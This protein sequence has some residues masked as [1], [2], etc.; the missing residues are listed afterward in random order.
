MYW[1]WYFL[2]VTQPQFLLLGL[3]GILGKEA[4]RAANDAA[5]AIAIAVVILIFIAALVGI[6][7][8]ITQ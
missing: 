5:G 6:V 8:L 7:Y 2:F 3:F 1:F 4:E